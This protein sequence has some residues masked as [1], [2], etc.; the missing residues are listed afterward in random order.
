M[1]RVVGEVSFIALDFIKRHRE[2]RHGEGRRCDKELVT[3]N[4]LSL[5][6][7]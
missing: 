2:G 4:R 3:D 6:N 5:T 1:G 7:S